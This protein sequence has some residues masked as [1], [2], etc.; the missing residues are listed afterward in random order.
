[1]S[2]KKLGLLGITIALLLLL[3]GNGPVRASGDTQFKWYP[4]EQAARITS[5]NLFGSTLRLAASQT[6]AFTRG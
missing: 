2:A 4:Q 3:V 1:M 6:R 5:Q